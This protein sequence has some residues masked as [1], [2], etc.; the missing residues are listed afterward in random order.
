MLEK[1]IT[2]I[3]QSLP[4]A[5]RRKLGVAGEVTPH[6]QKR[7]EAE[8]FNEFSSVRKNKTIAQQAVVSGAEEEDRAKKRNSMIFKVIIILG[9]AYIVVDEFILKDVSIDPTTEEIIAAAAAKKKKKKIVVAEA[10]I[11]T[12]TEAQT[13]ASAETSAAPT[14]D[15]TPPIENV[16]VL[17]KTEP[18]TEAPVVQA[19]PE[20]EVISSTR[21]TETSNID[22]K[23]DQLV[24]NVDQN[25]NQNSN[26]NTVEE[27]KIPSQSQVAPETQVA[28]APKDNFSSMASKITEDAAVETPAPAYDQVGRGLVYN[29][30]DKYWACLNKPAFLTC[31]KNMLWNKSKGNPAEC[32]VKDIYNSDEDC[33]KVQK[34]NVSSNVATAF[35]N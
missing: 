11:E 10:A 26:P 3:K 30:K 2:N 14:S 20:P 4:E 15:P 35:C 32:V 31:N 18:V 23:L 33:A 28:Q 16:N 1:L 9:I 25:Q 8:E 21:I 22:Q 12:Q 19:E 24:E 17:E 34:Y 29:C 6:L 13:E 5:L 7:D 27:I